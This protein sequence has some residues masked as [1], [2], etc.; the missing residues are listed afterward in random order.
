MY[1]VELRPG[2]EELYRTGDELAAAIRSGEVD[3]HSRIYHRATSKWISITL[4]PQYK[5]IITERPARP[6]PNANDLAFLG[7]QAETLEGAAQ[8]PAR[9]DDIASESDADGEGGQGDNPWRRPLA[10]GISG[11]FLL[12]GIQL[13]FSGP[14]PQWSTARSDEP[15]IPAT[16]AEQVAAER[17]TSQ[18]VVSLASTSTGWD[19]EP[20]VEVKA[21]PAPAPKSPAVLPKAPRVA[22]KLDASMPGS[23]AREADPKTVEGLLADYGKAYEDARSRLGSGVRVARLNQ[24]FALSRLT[25]NGGITDTRLGLAGVANF[26]RVYR[27]QESSIER[28]YQDSFTTMSQDLGWTPKVAKRWYTREVGKESEELTTLTDR[29]IA[30]IDSVLAILSAEAGAY[31]L[32]NGK[33]QFED[34]VVARQYGELRRNINTAMDAARIAGGEGSAGPMGYLLRAIGSTRLPVES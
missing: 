19:E 24:L 25:P 11:L 18:Q 3:G 21:E 34:P 17:E 6:T 1:L 23:G 4:H 8:P 32:A 13:A 20:A 16:P 2:K 12:F 31:Q 26:I 5:A 9:L 27:Q 30:K 22:M 7:S 33:I 28:T 10:F 29:L 15:E 14:R